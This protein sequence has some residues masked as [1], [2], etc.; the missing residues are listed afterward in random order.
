[1]VVDERERIEYSPVL[2]VVNDGCYAAGIA[3]AACLVSG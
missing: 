1:M 2:N 3:L